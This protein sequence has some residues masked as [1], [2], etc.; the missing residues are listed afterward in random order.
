MAARDPAAARFPARTTPVHV[1]TV[2]VPTVH[3][4][5]FHL[6]GLHRGVLQPPQT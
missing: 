2:Y 3:H 6:T 4:Q 5:T 1:L